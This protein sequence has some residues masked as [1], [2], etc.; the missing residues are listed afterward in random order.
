MS[1]G[2]GR[3]RAFWKATGFLRV[4][5]QL[6]RN[7]QIGDWKLETRDTRVKERNA[8]RGLSLDAER[9][10]SRAHAAWSTTPSSRAT[11]RAPNSAPHA[12][13]SAAARSGEH[14]ATARLNLR[15]RSPRLAR[16]CFRSKRFD[17]PST[18]V[19]TESIL[20]P[21]LQPEVLGGVNK[22]S[23]RETLLLRAPRLSR[24]LPLSF[25]QSSPPP[26]RT[27][28]PKAFWPRCSLA[29]VARRMHRRTTPPGRQQRPAFWLAE[30]E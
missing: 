19:L 26:L 9:R 27:P 5:C 3:W 10:K 13:T 25:L 16:G 20:V 11:P 17:D 7:V 1:R 23:L 29:R 18:K 12:A 30:I 28:A 24:A 4:K 22:C 6:S 14:S 8:N 15:A 2:G 21:T